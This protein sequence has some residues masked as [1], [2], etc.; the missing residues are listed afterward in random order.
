M[1]KLTILRQ[2]KLGQR[3]FLPALLHL[4]ALLLSG[5]SVETR[6]LDYLDGKLQLHGFLTQGVV[7][8]SDNNFLGESTGGGSLDFREIGMNASLRVSPDLQIAGQIVSHRAGEMDEGDPRLDYGLLD[9]TALSGEWGRGGVRLGRIKLPFGLYNETRDVASTRS[10]VILPQSIYF[11]LARNVELSVDGLGLYLDRN[12]EYGNF[13][14]TTHAGRGNVG[15]K[16]TVTGFLGQRVAGK[17]DSNLFKALNL[18]Y[19]AD[20]GRVRLGVTTWWASMD[21]QPGAADPVQAG[22]GSFHPIIFSA[23]YNAENWSLTAEHLVQDLE[24]R[25]FG[26]RPDSSPVLQSDYLQGTY[27]LTPEW[28]VMLRYDVLYLDRSDRD[29]KK[30][31]AAFGTPPF[32]LFA[33][34]WTAGLRY[35]VTPNFMVRAEYHRI[36]GT[37]WLSPLEN[38][39]PLAL[40]QHWDMFMLLGSFYF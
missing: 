8:T 6:A 17:F 40:E 18:L 5:W 16:S 2:L 19:E 1:N 31:A 29:G 35:D 27:R 4:M 21:Y 11:E 20:G 38:P 10:G 12:T 13:Y 7:F 25:G 15:D 23:Q 28:E 37:G 26:V 24:Y 36:N 30:A 33:R 22:R 3:G 32:M 39:N 9:W 34:D 14:F